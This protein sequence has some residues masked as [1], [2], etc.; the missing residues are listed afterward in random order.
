M[1]NLLFTSPLAFLVLVGG[2]ILALAVH[3]MA[4]AFLAYR[5]GDNTAKNEGRLTLN[6]LAH[7]DLLGLAALIFFRF[8]WGKAVPVNP[9]NFRHPRLDNFFVALAGP[10]TNLL[11]AF[12]FG[13]V[14]RLTANME[15]M[16]A[17]FSALTF[18]NILLAL[19]NLLPI[20][21]LDGSKVLGLFMRHESYMELE[22]FGPF[23]LIAFLFFASTTSLPLYQSFINIV[24]RLTSLFVN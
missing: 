7:L 9:N 4:H 24:E 1:I 19:F 8:G 23:I 11:L 21:P 10:I 16:A 15:I 6:P 3:E 14:A 22:R 12:I 20:P 5:L 18:I 2:I 13:T 17:I